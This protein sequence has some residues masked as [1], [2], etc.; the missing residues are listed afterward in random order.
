VKGGSAELAELVECV[1]SVGLVGKVRLVD[2]LL[3]GGERLG[4]LCAEL[5]LALI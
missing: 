1:R 3:P 4:L 5:I 2:R